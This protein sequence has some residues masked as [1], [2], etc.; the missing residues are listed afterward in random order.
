MFRRVLVANRGV[1]A[2]RII[3]TLR[4]MGIASVA[5]YSAADRQS[6]H[7][8]QADE[9]VLIGNAPANESYL[10]SAALIR[11]ARDT[12]A[13][14]IHPGYGLLCDDAGF[15]AACEAAGITFIGPRSE[16]LEVFSLKHRARELAQALR[17][18]LLPASPLLADLVAAQTVAAKYG[19]PVMLKSTVK[20]G[21]IGPQRIGS[22][23]DLPE[24]FSTTERLALGLRDSGLY[25]EKYVE[26][27]RHLEVQVLG[28]G[29]GRV[30]T[31]GERDCSIQRRNGKVVDESPAP[32]LDDVVRAKLHDAATRLAESVRYRSAGSVEF[33]FDT[34]TGQLHFLEFRMHLPAEHAV[35]EE[36]HGID[37]V[38]LT[39]RIAANETRVIEKLKRDTR[40]VSLQVRIHAEV[41]GRGFQRSSGLLT[42]V[43]F[44]ANTRVETWV[45]RGTEVTSFYDPLLAEIVVHGDTRQNAIAKL[46]AALQSTRITG[47]ETNL[48]YLRSVLSEPAFIA[49]LHTTRLLEHI[50]WQPPVVHVLE[51]GVQTSI[52]DWPG[53]IGYWDVG[54]PPSGPMDEFA[55][56][57]ANG[58]VGNQRSGRSTTTAGLECTMTGPTLRFDSD[59]VIAVTGAPTDLTLDGEPLE[60]WTSHAITAGSV[61]KIGR[62]PGPGCRAY[63]AIAGGLDVPAYLGSRSTFMF[64]KFGGHAGRSLRAGDVLHLAQPSLSAT[65][66]SGATAPEYPRQWT[67]GVLIGPHAAPDFFTAADI[68][69]LLEST[70]TVHFNSSRAGIRLVGPKPQ[71][72]R[73][74]GGEAGLH[75]SS[76]HDNAYAIGSIGFSGDQPIIF[77]P[78]GPSLGGVVCP[79]VV[80]QAELWKL[81]QIRP[82]D[83][84]RFVQVTAR[85]AAELA[86]QLERRIEAFDLPPDVETLLTDSS[87]SQSGAPVI[88]PSPIL[89]GRLGDPIQVAGS[90]VAVTYRQAGDAYVLVEYG[91]GILD[92]G[93]RMRVQALIDAI[94]ASGTV[95][96]LDLTP[97]VRSLQIHFDPVRLPRARLLQV[98]ERIEDALPAPDD[99][100]VPSRIVH[101]PLAWNDST[102]ERAAER[103]MQSVRAEAPW[104]PSN[105]EFIRRVN[106]LASI[107]AVRDIVYGASHLVLGL[108]DVYLGAPVTTPIDPRHRL[109]APKI[110]PPRTWTPE[111][112]V[113][114][115]GPY[116]CV[117]GLEGP[118]AHQLVGRTLQMWNRYRVTS[119]FEWNRPWLLRVFDQIRFFPVSEAE[120]TGLREDFPAGRYKLRIEPG[121]FSL[122][123]HRE[124]L[125]RESVS[126]QSF[127][128]GQQAALEAERER[129]RGA[130]QVEAEEERQHSTR[131]MRQLP[132]GSRTIATPVPGSLWKVLKRPGDLVAVDEPVLIVE[133]MQTEFPVVSPLR[134]RVLG[135]LCREGAAVNAGQD[136]LVIEPL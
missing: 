53:R 127:R 104:C 99:L 37:L 79:A 35:T 22:A 56:R 23:A 80:V 54:V 113:G 75:P 28:D 55:F 96:L 1:A 46:A 120:L 12:G 49:G 87:E 132:E 10:S 90:R 41:P 65:L 48:A 101:L 88:A 33:L 4:R 118:G 92:L 26:H 129:W 116:L 19:Y 83:A 32:E 16:T 95:G 67:L 60:M 121:T 78:D 70:W 21:G 77:G 44:P 73:A 58:L 97:G 82:G 98:L 69:Q 130:G 59:A 105:L 108:G 51:S 52:Q 100:E 91:G 17:I 111:N 128:Q 122:R 14:A 125:A 124:F 136:I 13:D 2:C 103:Y 31:L 74:D 85:A 18:P 106:G 76:V 50:H 84:L 135:L 5:V 9:A 25:L 43:R 112:A 20:G 109:T 57:V 30:V 64:G 81:G 3:R 42:D 72:A 29:R 66:L 94:R 24:L 89:G 27:A 62:I 119:E 38:E 86:R 114:I 8:L 61:L 39:L 117:Y 131:G 47:I 93:L 133:S 11:A 134:G 40:G 68:E 126:I 102:V 107:D 63:L 36:V 7:V 15:A 123:R 6:L 115:G 110:N 45:E 34:A 71:W